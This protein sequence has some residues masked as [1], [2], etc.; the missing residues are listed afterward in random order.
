MGNSSSVPFSWAH[1]G[2]R[3]GGASTG[4]ARPK[5]YLVPEELLKPPEERSLLTKVW[6]PFAFLMCGVESKHFQVVLPDTWRESLL[7]LLSTRDL[8]AL[9]LA[10]KETKVGKSK[11]SSTFQFC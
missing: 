9:Q 4:A 7:P 8:L 3:D 5:N 1:G 11:T 6:W 2:D 10:C